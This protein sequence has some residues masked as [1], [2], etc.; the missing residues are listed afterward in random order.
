MPILIKHLRVVVERINA[1]A[2]SNALMQMDI[3]KPKETHQLHG[4]HGEEDVGVEVQVDVDVGVGAERAQQHRQADGEPAEGVHQHA[5]PVGHDVQRRHE[6]R[7]HDGEPEV[8]NGKWMNCAFNDLRLHDSTPFT[9]EKKRYLQDDKNPKQN[10]HVRAKGRLSRVRQRA[11]LREQR[12]HVVAR[13]VGEEA[14]DVV[15]FDFCFLLKT[16]E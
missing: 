15:H 4:A 2:K 3:K 11:G 14:V 6:L 13:R 16:K 9:I 12:H 8:S 7:V 1:D 5:A 10:S